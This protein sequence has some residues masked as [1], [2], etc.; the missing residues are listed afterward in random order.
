MRQ[1]SCNAFMEG[2]HDKS[3][4][5]ERQ[6][7]MELAEYV[8][9]PDQGMWHGYLKGCPTFEAYGD[10]FEELQLKLTR[11]Y[12]DSTGSISSSASSD[13]ALLCW[14]WQRRISRIRDEG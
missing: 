6:P 14:D 3:H 7:S 10:S 5:L 9:M 11:L 13:T 4:P 12:P 1:D 2:W 8:F